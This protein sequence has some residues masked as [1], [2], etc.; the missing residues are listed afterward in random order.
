MGTSTSAKG[1]GSRS[2]L[3]PPHADADPG[4]PL[5]EP[6]GQRF[7]GFRT[8]FGHV[9]AGTG[10]SLAKALHK[11][12]RDATGGSSVGP[13]RFGPAYTAGAGFADLLGELGA[14]GTGEAATGVDLSGLAGQ[15]LDVAAQEIAAALAPDNA[16]ADQVAAAIQEA[17]AEVLVDQQTFDPAAITSDQI[18]ALLVEFFS[19][20]VFQEISQV[21][22]EAW[23][24]SPNVLR[25]TATE[26]ELLEL[27]RAAID[28]HLSPRLA[29]GVAGL[30]KAE[31]AALERDAL[32]DVWAEW[33]AE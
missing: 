17:M 15:P 28:K 33:E 24:K 12:A 16:D 27:V 22:G 29:Q 26:G 20:I 19:Q 8:E 32:T 25:T 9:A 7:R 23:T 30:S 3:V 5:P 21:A 13:R 11:Y 18:V 6:E 1:P 10:G 2:P 14:G 4:Q 31:I